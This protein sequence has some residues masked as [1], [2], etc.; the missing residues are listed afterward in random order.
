MAERQKLREIIEQH[1]HVVVE[2]D[3]ASYC[4]EIAKYHNPQC[5]LV[6]PLLPDNDAISL[7]PS[8]Q[9]LEI[10]IIAIAFPPPTSDSATD[11]QGL[12]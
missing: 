8:L 7:I 3:N 5:V 4:L 1:D 11:I 10:P 2:A 12:E 9:S 6:N